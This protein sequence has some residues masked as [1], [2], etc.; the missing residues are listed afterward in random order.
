MLA[1]KITTIGLLLFVGIT[2]CAVTMKAFRTTTQDDG[3]LSSGNQS[4][5]GE[6]QLVELSPVSDG[7]IA[8]YFHGDYRCATCRAI[9]SLAH[10]AMK[11]GF[12]EELAQGM[13]QWQT[14]NYDKPENKA[15]REHYGLVAP[16]VV[17]SKR[18]NGNEVAWKSL[19]QVWYFTHDRGEF[20]GY[21][22]EE[23]RK[24]REMAAN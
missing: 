18:D 6:A 12:S 17:L 4:I 13:I 11:E 24:L 3:S 8:Y 16:I 2:F 23:T 10:E 9:E 7:V 15:A 14:V 5:A 22:Q 21:V 20:F 19:D 1:R